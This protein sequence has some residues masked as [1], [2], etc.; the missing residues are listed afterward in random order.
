[1]ALKV[2]GASLKERPEMYWKRALQ[3]LQKGEPADESHETRLLHQMEASL[4]NLDATTREC[5]LDLGA[6]P[7]DR[8]IPV[9]VLINMWIEIH[10]LEEAIAFATLVDL[11]HKNLLTLGKDPR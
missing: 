2:T 7:E 3:R 6:F 10:D 11:S 8:K 4:E 1:M 9:D 5:F